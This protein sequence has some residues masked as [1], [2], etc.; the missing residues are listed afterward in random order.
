MLRFVLA[1]AS[2]CIFLWS[3]LILNISLDT[4]VWQ[5]VFFIINIFHG[6]YL[7][8]KLRPIKFKSQE[9][10]DLYQQVFASPRS[11]MGRLDFMELS[12]LGYLRE[13]DKGASF[14]EWGSKVHS[15]SIL[16]SGRIEVINFEP[17]SCSSRN[18]V[19]INT[20][21]PFEYIESPQWIIQNREKC[22]QRFVVAIRASTNCRYITW[23]IENLQRLFD[24]DPRFLVFIENT[25]GYDVAHKLLKTDLA[26]QQHVRPIELDTNNNV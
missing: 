16:M 17:R 11:A 12:N 18:E 19:S 21:E 1:S 14:A 24:K 13:L 5:G 7:L 9:F 6:S 10:E 8:W 15:L 2:L 22:D 3:L 23:P 20:I 25:V 26:R 4:C